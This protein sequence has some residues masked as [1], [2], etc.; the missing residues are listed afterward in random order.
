MKAHRKRRRE[1][2]ISLDEVITASRQLALMDA[3]LSVQGYARA[4]GRLYPCR[5]GTYTARVVW[6]HRAAGL[7]IAGTAQGLRLA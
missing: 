6:R 4:S 7:S 2:T 3:S 5:D 1:R